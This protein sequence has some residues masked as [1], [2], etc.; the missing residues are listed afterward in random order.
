[1]KWRIIIRHEGSSP[2]YKMSAKNVNLL[3]LLIVWIYFFL[4]P[5]YHQP[6]RLRW[7]WGACLSA[8][9][10]VG[11][12]GSVMISLPLMTVWK[13]FPDLLWCGRNLL[14]DIGLCRSVAGLDERVVDYER[15]LIVIAMTVVQP[16]A[17]SDTFTMHRQRSSTSASKLTYRSDA[18]NFCFATLTCRFTEQQFT[19]K[20]CGHT[21]VMLKFG[22]VQMLTALTRSLRNLSLCKGTVAPA[23]EYL[24]IHTPGMV[25]RLRC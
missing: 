13:R 4:S 17:A 24:P 10:K 18:M 14:V 1:M 20:H 12:A 2:Y 7:W 19:A 15:D 22:K 5:T 25:L 6:P 8:Y 11:G 23:C 9:G 3:T 21:P 16:Q